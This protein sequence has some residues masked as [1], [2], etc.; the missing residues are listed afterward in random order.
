MSSKLTPKEVLENCPPMPSL[1]PKKQPG[2]PQLESR[3]RRHS[4]FLNTLPGFRSE[5]KA[6]GCGQIET[7]QQANT[8]Y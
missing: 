6:A 7:T 2:D 4:S 1:I 5:D 3:D 8:Q